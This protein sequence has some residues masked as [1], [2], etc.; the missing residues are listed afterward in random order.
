MNEYT[1]GL[2][3]KTTMNNNGLE[4]VVI[5][6]KR[7]A[8]GTSD[9]KTMIENNRYFIDKTL[10]VKDFL[11]DSGDIVLLPRPRRFGKTLNLSIIRYFLEKSDEDNSHLFKGLKI[12]K[13]A[14]I[15]NKQG[16]YPVIYLTFK[17]EKHNDFDGF[18]ESMGNRISSLYKSFYYIYDSLK[19]DDDR[20]YFDVMINRK[21]TVKDLEISVFRLSEFLKVYHNSK[22]IILLDEYDTPIHEGHFKNYYSEIVGFMRN[23]LSSALKDNINLEKAMIT[24][25]LRVAKESIFSGLNNLEVYS[26]LSERYSDK[27]G[28][29]EKETIDLLKYYSLDGS[30][31]GFKA[32]YN[33]YIFG[34]TTIYNPWSV[35]SYINKPDRE[36]MPYWVNTSEN[37]IIKS[38]LAEGSEEIK[39]GLENLYNGGYV[40]TEVNEDV[41]MSEL[42]NGKQNIWS[43]LLLSGYLKPIEKI[44]VKNKFIYKLAIPNYE[45]TYLYESII[46]KWFSE[47]FISNDFNNML[48]A[49]VLGEVQLFEEYFSDY[50]LKSFSYF[51]ISGENPERVYHAFI[52]GMLVSL[53]DTYEVISNRES[54]LGRYD[55]SLIPKDITKIGLIMEFKSI[56]INSKDT[57]EGAMDKAITQVNKKLYDTELKA[58]GVNNIIKLALVFKG[59]EVLIRQA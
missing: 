37:S 43:F 21:G 24:G 3:T 54:G 51:D 4:R 57:L 19:F 48:K 47:S 2:L 25:I 1:I 22:V 42:R 39:L 34:S 49:L 45:I 5:E 14:E 23:F 32:W 44:R 16:K 31:T 59:K 38:L 13:D 29:T 10:I 33:G 18:I 30:L 11:E 6:M 41:V 50:V 15:M 7:I 9:F 55:V 52:L 56:R 8:L 40:E 17:D 27:F 35:L 28:F 20:N 58:R 26:L 12:E 53:N 36:F 46:E